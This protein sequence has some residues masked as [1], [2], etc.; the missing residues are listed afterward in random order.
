MQKKLFKLA[1]KIAL[2]GLA[3][4]LVY[5]KIDWTKTKII[6]GSIHYGWLALGFLVFTLSRIVG[7]LRLNLYF[8]Q[9]GLNLSEIVNL[10][11]Y[12]LGMFY[13]LFLPG[14]IGGD[15]YKIYFLNKYYQVRKIPLLK[16]TLL[17]RI[18]GLYALLF[19]AALTFSFST[20][21]A[22]FELNILW[23]IMTALFIFPLSYLL[24]LLFFKIFLPIFTSS[25]LYAVL[26]QGLQVVS[27]LFILYALQENRFIF[28]Y[29]TIF[30]ISS[31]VAVLP[32]SIGGI[33]ARELTF[34]Y[35]FE[36]LERDYNTGVALS[37]L[38]FMF[39][40]IS[41]LWGALYIHISPHRPNT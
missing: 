40:F 23:P 8:T 41:S 17:D 39:T 5:H 30:L 37:V 21:I 14:G 1:I 16:A 18:S 13:N 22:R 4:Y 3:L 20:F 28:D 7:A 11:L 12:Y 24:N 34:I 33:G 31:L 26:L 35:L 9:T 6:F 29:L 27:A 2:T 10:K 19:L 15:G 36:F 25:T 38:F 32:V